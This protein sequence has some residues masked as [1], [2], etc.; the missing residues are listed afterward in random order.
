MGVP[1]ELTKR[2]REIVPF[3][4]SGATRFEIANHFGV[5]DE[6]I[7]VHTRN[8]LTKFGA[9]SLRDV[10]SDI[11]EYHTYYGDGGLGFSRYIVDYDCV[12]V[13]SE[14]GRDLTMTERVTYH[15]VANI[16]HHMA[17]SL[18]INEPARL[19]RFETQS[20][21]YCVVKDE[22]TDSQIRKV[23]YFDPPLRAG[24]IVTTTDTWVINDRYPRDICEEVSV[25]SGPGVDRSVE[26]RFLRDPPKTIEFGAHLSFNEVKNAIVSK[27]LGSHHFK[28]KLRPSVSGLRFFVKWSKNTFDSD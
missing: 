10:F 22:G 25:F 13:V 1:P 24:E 19:E 7:K 12:Y 17:S 15:M 27:E 11:I 8:I 4:V 9:T 3:L 2:E 23:T 26:L 21:H 20:S 18:I 28:F 16:T 14:N 6:T 5:S